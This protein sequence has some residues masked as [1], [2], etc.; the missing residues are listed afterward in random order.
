MSRNR[1]IVCP[2]CEGKGIEWVAVGDD[3]YDKEPCSDCDGAGQIQ[4]Y[5]PYD[6]YTEYESRR[7]GL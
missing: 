5:E 3:D 6:K 4:E 7:G 1:L 2:R